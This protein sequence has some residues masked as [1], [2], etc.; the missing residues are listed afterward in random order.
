MEFLAGAVVAIVVQVA[1]KLGKFDMF[2]TYAFLAV[3][4]L[5]AAY[6][7]LWFV[8]AGYWESVLQ[9][10]VVAGSVHNFVLRRFEE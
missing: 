4:S 8:S 5:V 1:K 10:L 6:V 2:Y 9:V 7:Y 3:T